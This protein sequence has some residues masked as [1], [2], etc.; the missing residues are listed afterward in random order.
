MQKLYN[1]LSIAIVLIL[2]FL[3]FRTC[4]SKENFEKIVEASK[5][6]LTTWRDKNGLEHAKI[7]VLEGSVSDLKKLNS[8]K[9]SSLRKLQAIVDKKTTMAI[10]LNTTTHNKGKGKTTVIV[11]SSEHHIVF[12]TVHQGDCPP[13]PKLTYTTTVN[14]PWLKGNIIATR[15]SFHYDLKTFNEYNI[16]EKREREKF[17]KEKTLKIEITNKNPNTSTTGI[18]AWVDQKPKVRRGIIFGLGVIA[19][20][21]ATIAG[22]Q[23]I[24]VMLNR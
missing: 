17:W 20:T 11:D 8:Q 5:D 18:K 21:A 6:S 7:S 16:V 23:G 1:I 13:C 10:V 24:K 4:E 9:D 14:E 3:L 2:F 15:D 22:Q 19:G 12:D